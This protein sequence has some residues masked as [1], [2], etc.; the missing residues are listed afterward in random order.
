[1]RFALFFLCCAVLGAAACRTP[2]SDTGHTVTAEDAAARANDAG[3]ASGTGANTLG[4]SD[5]VEVRVFQEPDLSNAYRVSPEGTIDYP[6]CGKVKLTGM[7]SSQ[8]ADIL[9]SCLKNGYLKNPQV[10]VLIREFNSKKVYVFGWVQ[11]A[12]TFPFEENMNVVQA[13]TM[14]GGFAPRAA[15]NDA[16]VTRLVDGRE[17]RIPVRIELIGQGREKNFLLQPGD[18]LWVPESIF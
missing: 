4:T 13:V 7:T 14:A 6:F 5:L 17:D 18:I 3:G 16:I 15:P 12:G 8:A 10:S 2:R 9:T 1:L 11:K